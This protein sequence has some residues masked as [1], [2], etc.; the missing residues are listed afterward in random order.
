MSVVELR[1]SIEQMEA[2]LSDPSWDPDPE[3][4]EQW[5]DAFQ[6]AATPVEK[7]EEWRTLVARAHAV[8]KQV[9]ARI[10][11]LSQQLE[12][13]KAELVAQERGSR[14]LKGYEASTR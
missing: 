7:G 13:T 8:G 3:R 14:A 4:L 11:S 9:E 1:A 12:A 6:A 10:L 5:N 2:W